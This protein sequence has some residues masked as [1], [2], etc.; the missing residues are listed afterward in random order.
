M[1]PCGTSEAG[2]LVLAISVT[3]VGLLLPADS[4]ERCRR[5]G[6]VD[7]CC[8]SSTLYQFHNFPSRQGETL[9]LEDAELSVK[10]A[11]MG[12]GLVTVHSF[13]SFGL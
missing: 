10:F 5:T 6:P 4:V 2:A 3:A 1:L 9:L 11:S 7:L 12:S 8:F 13:L